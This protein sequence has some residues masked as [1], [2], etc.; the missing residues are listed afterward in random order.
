M[1]NVNGA[2]AGL[3]VP[4]QQGVIRLREW[5]L[6]IRPSA[7]SLDARGFHGGTA[8]ARR[9]LEEHA[10]SFATG[11]NA[12]LAAG[13]DNDLARRLEVV[14]LR[15]RGF[16]YE[17]AAMALALFDLL[18]PVRGRRFG[19]LLHGH[20]RPHRYMVHVG[21]GWAVARLRRRP[22][23]M[24]PAFDPLLR[25]LA[26]DG[27]GFHDGF[28][29]TKRAVTQMAR[30]RRLRGYARRAYDQGLGRS[31]W[32]VSG[33]DPERAAATV[34]SFAPERR[35]DLWSGLGLAASYT[36]AA[37]SDDVWRLAQL[38]RRSRPHVV[39]G[40]AFAVTA[41]HHAGNPVPETRTAAELL[42]GASVEAVA[43]L[44]DAARDGLD[45]DPGGIAYECWRTRI[46]D[47]L[48]ARIIRVR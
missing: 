41:R 3:T 7:T 18:G 24:L 35:D 40:A 46:R 28:F 19:R 32:F 21:A 2:S 26:L 1:T 31:L 48:Q 27:H 5:A 9:T 29:R 34:E 22:E 30:P 36:S 13:D 4:S 6:R 33:A 39:Q 12:A 38:A 14:S 8:T 10:G 43:R 15:D 20:G 11:F 42:C 16:A 47:R 17:G 23:T 45:G 25:W 37:V 44:V